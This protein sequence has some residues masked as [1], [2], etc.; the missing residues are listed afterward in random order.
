MQMTGLTK[1]SLFLFWPG[2][3]KGTTYSF[4][5]HGA[6][7]YHC[8]LGHFRHGD[9]QPTEQP[10]DPRASLPLTSEKAVFSIQFQSF[11]NMQ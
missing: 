6:A 3:G 9:K 11:F 8:V 2:L 4:D 5:H 10:G 7:D 1:Y